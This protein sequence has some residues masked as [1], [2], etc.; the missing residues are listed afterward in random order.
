MQKIQAPVSEKGARLLSLDIFRGMTIALMITVNNPGLED[1]VYAPLEHA[2]WNGITPTDFVFPSFV[3]IMGVSIALSYSRQRLKGVSTRIMIARTLRRAVLLFA[4]GVLLSV[5]PYFDLSHYRLP[6]VLQRLAIV[7]ACCVP[8]F[9]YTRWRTQIMIA[10]FILIGYFLLIKLAPV[11]GYGYPI[12]EPGRNWAAWL[13][14]IVI[15][16][17]LWQGSWDP[18]GILSTFP[19][20]VSGM[21]GLLT[22]QLLLSEKTAE[23]KIILFFVTGF[24]AFV[25]ACGWSAFFPLNKNLWTSTFVLYVGGIDCMILASLYYIVDLLGYNKGLGW[26][27]IFGSNAIAAYLAAEVLGDLLTARWGNRQTGFCLNEWLMG[28]ALNSGWSPELLSLLWALFFCGLCFLPIWG[29]Y[30]K[31]IFLKI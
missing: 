8:L 19:A 21:G 9:L 29:L 22:G 31:K 16:G 14:R 4:L 28:Q 27:R 11:P 1:H 12:M 6:G 3:F 30:Q 13:D 26:A 7:Y 20:I 5:L 17:R 23:R 10:L 18:E 2:R 15:P 25:A 24:A